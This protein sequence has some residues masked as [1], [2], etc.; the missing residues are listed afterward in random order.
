MVL[1]LSTPDQAEPPRE[2]EKDGFWSLRLRR[3]WV[4][5]V[6]V[7]YLPA[8]G[9]TSLIHERVGVVV[10]VCWMIAYAAAGMI[11]ASSKCPRCGERCFQSLFWNAW[12]FRCAH[13]GVR[14]YWSDDVLAHSRQRPPEP[15][16]R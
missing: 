2:S 7:T 6:L 16:G 13:C 1:S 12:A 9:M 3:R 8:A 10:A 11:L 4:L 5:T 15:A 14:L